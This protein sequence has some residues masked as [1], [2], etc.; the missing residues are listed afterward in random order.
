MSKDRTE[1]RPIKVKKL[2]PGDWIVGEKGLMEV[3]FVNDKKYQEVTL[4][5]VGDPLL[6]AILLQESNKKVKVFRVVKDEEISN[7]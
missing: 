6:H 1:L 2:L 7:E 5:G 4:R 3:L